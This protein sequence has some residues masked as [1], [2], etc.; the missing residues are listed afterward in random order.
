MLVQGGKH[1]CQTPLS[2][3]SVCVRGP[4][5]Q[6][7][8]VPE[9]FFGEHTGDTNFLKRCAEHVA[10]T[11]REY[12]QELAKPIAAALSEFLH[13]CNVKFGW[14]FPTTGGGQSFKTME[15]LYAA[16]QDVDE[17]EDPPVIVEP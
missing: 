13:H 11:L 16:L 1:S 9:D 14:K 4:R 15:E 3:V 7:K 10:Q 12:D 8:E 17:G 2:I 5:R 6:V